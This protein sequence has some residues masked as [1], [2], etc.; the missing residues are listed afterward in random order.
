MTGY[1]SHW[2]AEDATVKIRVQE[3]LKRRLKRAASAAD[4]QVKFGQ[5]PS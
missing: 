4:L 1:L 3:G 2:S 5:R